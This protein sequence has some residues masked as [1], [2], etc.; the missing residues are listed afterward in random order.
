MG[1]T[2]RLGIR[3]SITTR[4][5]KKCSTNSLF[6][7]ATSFVDSLMS[8]LQVFLVSLIPRQ[9]KLRPTHCHTSFPSYSL[10]LSSSFFSYHCATTKK[11]TSNSPVLFVVAPQ[12][13]TFYF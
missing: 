13:G 11:K 8:F 9:S 6:G 1:H 7:T 4:R 2:Q 3:F 10:S 12:K 5:R